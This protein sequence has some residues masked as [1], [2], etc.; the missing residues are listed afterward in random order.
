M[1]ED[2]SISSGP[3][4]GALGPTASGTQSSLQHSAATLDQFADSGRVERKDKQLRVDLL[5]A[6]MSLELWDRV[7]AKERHIERVDFRYTIFSN[8]Y[9]RGCQ[10]VECDFTGAFFVESNLRGST[11]EG[12]K[13]DYARF[14]RTLVTHSIIDRSM[15]GYENV[16]LELARSL[17]ANFGQIGDTEGAN[18]A[19]VAELK[20]TRV[21]Y[22]KAAWSSE[23]YYR[24][25]Y[26]G[27][28]RAQMIG[29]H[30]AFVVLDWIW[31]NGESFTRVTITTAGVLCVLA[32][33][34]YQSGWPISRAVSTSVPLF[35]GVT[36]IA[37]GLPF[38]IQTLAAVSRFVL[39]GL[40]MSVLIKRLA[41]R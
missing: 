8:C 16:Q 29:K 17:R 31:G 35:F 33:S 34:I 19:I 30:A 28:S 18:K 5:Q 23:A 7:S 25:K 20:A 1:H 24:K 22:H 11:F 10:F 2:R 15:P 26:A 39:F 27:W 40:F 3:I 37:A 9:L 4:A 14:S 13:F 38:W 21:H 12:C 6:T 32:W 41:R 36:A